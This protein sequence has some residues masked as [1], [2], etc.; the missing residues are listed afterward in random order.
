MGIEVR[1]PSWAYSHIILNYML[2]SRTEE[3]YL[4]LWTCVRVVFL[5]GACWYV[6]L[7][8]CSVTCRSFLALRGFSAS[9]VGDICTAFQSSCATSSLSLRVR[10]DTSKMQKGDTSY[11]QPA[12]ELQYGRLNKSLLCVPHFS[13]GFQ[14]FEVLN[15]K[16]KQAARAQNR[17]TDSNL[18]LISCS[19]STWLTVMHVMIIITLVTTSVSLFDVTSVNSSL[20]LMCMGT[21]S[22]AI[23]TST[24]SVEV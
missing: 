16:E 22:P 5:I 10:F 18:F 20:W 9:D 11:L 6:V 13:C 4:S 21:V 7:G 1:L 2:I 24:T 17:E 19:A 23:K 3:L 8:L 15:R 12:G 14:Q